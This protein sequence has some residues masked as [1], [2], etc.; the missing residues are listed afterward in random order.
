[1]TDLTVLPQT[2]AFIEGKQ[3]AVA[4]KSYNDNP[5]AR[6][7][8]K[9]GAIKPSEETRIQFDAWES[10]RGSIGRPA[11]PQEVRDAAITDPSQ[12]KR[13]S[14]RYYASR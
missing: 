3:A 6:G 7:F 9:L 8:T 2:L 5:Y 10:G 4:G 1:M 12:F 11:T 14:N 13:K